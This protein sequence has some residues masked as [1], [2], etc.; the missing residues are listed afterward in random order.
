[1]TTKAILAT[2]LVLFAASVRAEGP[3]NP[4]FAMDTLANRGN[5]PLGEKLD[6][7]KRLGYAGLSW[8]GTS[9]PQIQNVLKESEARGLKVFT[10]Y[11][12]CPLAKDKLDVPENIDEVFAA[13]AGHETVV[14]LYLQSKDYKPSDTSGDAVAVPALQ[15]LAAR[16]A[17]HKVKL[18][19]YPHAGFWAESFG[20]CLR[21]AEKVDRENFGVSFNL[22]HV[23]KTGDE[24]N[25]A[26]LL[27]RSRP[28][29]FVVSLNGADADLGRKGS[30]DKL[31][32]PVGRGS[33]DLVPLL[34]QLQ[35]QGYEGPIGFQGYGIQ[36]N[37]EPLLRETME[38]WRKASAAAAGAEQTSSKPV[39]KPN[40]LWITCE[41]MS[42]VI[43]CYGDKFAVTPTL[44][45]LARDGVRYTQVF[46]AACVCTPARS[47]LITGMYASSLGSQ[48][49]RGPINPP[50]HVRCYS[51]H[52]RKAGYYCTNNVK[53][54]YNFKAPP[55]SWDES[56]AKA[57]W[58][59][60]K[61]DQPFFAV[62]NI[63]HTHQGQI[64]LP[65]AEFAK[66]TARLKPTDRHD[67][68]TIP[69]PP[70]YPD[71]PLV[72]KDMARFYDLVTAM[73]YEVA[74]R[75][76]E[77]EEAGVAD[78]T[79]VF[80]YSDHGSGMPRHKRALYDSGLHVPMIV[81]FPE[82]YQQLSPAQPGGTTDR[83]VSFVD[84]GPTV[85]SLAGVNVPANMQGHA[86]LGPQDTK[87][88]G[89]V[90]ALRDRV[91]ECF[92]LSRAVRDRRWKY[93]RNFM[94]HRPYLQLSDYSE[95]AAT[96]KE[97][98]RLNAEGKLVGHQKA[99]MQPTKPAEE[100]YDLEKDPIELDNLAGSPEHQ[101]VLARMRGVLRDW[102]L[103]TRDTAL[104][105]EA[106][107][108]RRAGG[109]T[110]W[111]MAQREDA[112]P[113]AKILDAAE[114]IGRDAPVS[115]RIASL[116]DPDAAVRYWGV[117]GLMAPGIDAQLAVAQLAKL[118]NDPAPDVRL[119]AAETLAR[120]GR[121]QEAI[122]AVIAG[123]QDADTRV[124]LH[125][126]AVLV[127]IGEKARPALPAMQ[128]FLREK[129]P[130]EYRLYARWA[131][132]HVLRNLGE[133]SPSAE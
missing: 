61:S 105:P 48:H 69:L 1:M 80:F 119:A 23:L 45:R 128:A 111:S 66:R 87:P 114:L 73:D 101:E 67:P 113:V 24:A 106:E 27:Q 34:K 29:L 51:E 60:R 117:V 2:V 38:G 62:F 6:D 103:Q 58:R 94:P 17:K 13:V 74:D 40:I 46:A 26:A 70:Y 5:E 43:G 25:V 16:A 102:M 39:G 110:I 125:A 30:W 95:P 131:L 84:F 93:I 31:I 28:R 85:L 63:M 47:T 72:R 35:K 107:M 50:V 126:A 41:D 59:N 10:L 118:L 122:S 115:K 90:F 33:Y 18:A 99:Y 49:L 64:R 12:G 132:G 52:L 55:G 19:L 97:L 100:L 129:D 4:F 42:P 130:D 36:G 120:L 78:N 65:N 14:W 57:H 127:A 56:S 108:F 71:T 3:P 121:E 32:Q 92:E 75:L 88:R 98:R 68:A 79:I 22:C 11:V 9:V 89:Y 81:R 86:F 53:E 21:I 82:K 96:V 37:R 124:Q 133:P 54:D 83:L 15:A 104:L 112:F 7:L 123:L 20:D 8:T 77:I 76:K 116:E 44:D 91:D 109:E